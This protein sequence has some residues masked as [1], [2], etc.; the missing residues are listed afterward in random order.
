MTV[1][2]ISKKLHTKKALDREH[3]AEIK[4]LSEAMMSEMAD[5]ITKLFK[6]V[7]MPIGWYIAFFDEHSEG[8]SAQNLSNLPTVISGFDDELELI[9]DLIDAEDIDAPA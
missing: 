5:E 9:H 8:A 7:P 3:K 1:V 4:T 2:D 6:L